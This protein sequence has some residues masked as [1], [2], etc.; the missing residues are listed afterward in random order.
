[1]AFRSRRIEKQSGAQRSAGDIQQPCLRDRLRV[2]HQRNAEP[3][4]PLAP[5]FLAVAP[6]SKADDAERD[7]KKS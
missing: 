5:D 3:L 1:L 6:G 4:G 2:S 7:G